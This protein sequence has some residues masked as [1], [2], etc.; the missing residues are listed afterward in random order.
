MKFRPLPTLTLLIAASLAAG[1]A[2]YAQLEGAER[3]VP[4][5]DSASTLE[6]TGVEVDVTGKAS[7]EARYEGWKQ[8]QSKGW[9][10]L[11]AKTTGNPINQ[12]PSLSDSV[13][14]SI[15][16]GIII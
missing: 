3:G 15:V 9:K 4:P 7:E 5:I 12:A 2:L 1:G 13:L 11:W 14:N 10:A 6:V 8:A 16:S